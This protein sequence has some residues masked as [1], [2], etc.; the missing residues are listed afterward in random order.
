MS[1]RSCFLFKTARVG[2]CTDCKHHEFRHLGD[3]KQNSYAG[4]VRLMHAMHQRCCLLLCVLNAVWHKEFI[5][6]VELIICGVTVQ[7]KGVPMICTGVSND[8]SLY[9][10]N[11]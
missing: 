2:T 1:I 4:S 3:V 5:Q 11:K 10:Y 9:M 7:C 8:M 6:D